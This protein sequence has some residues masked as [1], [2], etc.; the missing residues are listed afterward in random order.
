MPLQKGNLGL[1]IQIL[2][3][4]KLNNYIHLYRLVG[5][6]DLTAQQ[7]SENADYSIRLKTAKRSVPQDLWAAYGRFVKSVTEKKWR[8]SL[9]KRHI[10]NRRGRR[11]L[12]LFCIA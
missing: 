12:R 3:Q 2:G 6:E 4:L 10:E 8:D 1:K 11:V 5:H 9:G 7:I